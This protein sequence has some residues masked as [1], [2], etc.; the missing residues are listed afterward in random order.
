MGALLKRLWERG[1]HDVE[2]LRAEFDAG[3]YDLVISR[4]ALTRHVQLKAMRLGS[5]TRWQNLSLKLQERAS[6]CVLCFEIDDDLN[7]T[8]YYWLGAAPGEPLPPIDG[9]RTTRHAKGNAQGVKAERPA[10][11]KI[12]MKAFTLID[13]RKDSTAALDAVI[14]RLLGAVS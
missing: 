1:I 4:R 14:E 12:P 7:V 3:G 5:S 13:A 11:R 2:V 6:G 9:Y 8:G 10:L